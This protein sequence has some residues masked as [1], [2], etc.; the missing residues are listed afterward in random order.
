MS[1]H[2][3]LVRWHT[4]TASS[5]TSIPWLVVIHGTIMAIAWT[6]LAPFGVMMPILFRKVAPTTGP[7]AFWFVR[8]KMLLISACCATVV[9]VIVAVIMVDGAH[10]TVPHT[11]G[12]LIM[13]VIAL[14]QPLN[15]VLRPHVP[16]P[17]EPSDSPGRRK[18][19]CWFILHRTIGSVGLVL[20]ILVVLS[21]LLAAGAHIAFVVVVLVW[22]LA[23]VLFVVYKK[24]CAG[25]SGDVEPA[26]KQTGS[27]SHTNSSR[28]LPTALWGCSSS[29]IQRARALTHFGCPCCVCGVYVSAARVAQS[30]GGAN[31]SAATPGDGQRVQTRWWCRWWQRWPPWTL[32]GSGELFGSFQRRW[33]LVEGVERVDNTSLPQAQPIYREEASPRPYRTPRWRLSSMVP[34]KNVFFIL[35]NTSAVRSESEPA[36]C[37]GPA[38]GTCEGE[39]RRRKS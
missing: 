24:C 31:V 26:A 5:S 33:D 20:G 16:K 3:A 30:R 39:A 32:R 15:A 19:R 12:G 35:K 4:M 17:E 21:G 11:F 8:H 10:F 34:L 28:V 38:L 22:I 14:I 25:A 29:S 1:S 36:W 7:N 27:F 23:L 13:L 6:I 18:R 9:G 2:P 37:M